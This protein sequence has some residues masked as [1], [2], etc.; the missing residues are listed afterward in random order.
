MVELNEIVG[1]SIITFFVMLG[2]YGIY[3]I[4]NTDVSKTSLLKDYCD[5]LKSQILQD[6]NDKQPLGLVINEQQLFSKN[7]L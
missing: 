7:C 6:R 2:A 5:S 4:H 1:Y 3:L